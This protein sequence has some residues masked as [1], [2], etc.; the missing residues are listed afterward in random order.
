ML[1][2][3]KSVFKIENLRRKIIA[4][5]LLVLVYKVLATI[6]VPGVDTTG[7]SAILARDENSGLGFFSALM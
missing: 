3:I 7:L 2:S 6:P 5:L 1:E 4:T